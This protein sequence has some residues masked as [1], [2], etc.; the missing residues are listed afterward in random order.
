MACILQPECNFL[1]GYFRYHLPVEAVDI[2]VMITPMQGTH[3][4]RRDQTTQLIKCTP[5][6]SRTCP[7]ITLIKK[8]ITFLELEGKLGPIP[9]SSSNQLRPHQPD[10]N[11]NIR[12]VTKITEKMERVAPTKRFKVKTAVEPNSDKTTMQLPNTKALMN[13]ES[14][15]TLKPAPK[16][17]SPPL[18]DAPICAGTLWPKVGKLLGNLFETRKGWLI[19]PNY[20]NPPN[21]SNDNNISAD[22]TT[23]L[24]PPIKVEPKPEGQPTTSSK[25]EKCGWRPNCPFC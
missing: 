5:C 12:K 7:H 22:N 4:F 13:A 18:E 8:M 16:S 10:T 23:G 21:Y 14:Q 25:A 3:V 11:P 24:K 20:T 2:E 1:H 9:Q 19:P 17:R 6:S 15:N